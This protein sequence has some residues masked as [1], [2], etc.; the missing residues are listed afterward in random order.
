[1]SSEDILKYKNLGN[2]IKCAFA[3]SAGG[4]SI[5]IKG[6]FN[7]AF[8]FYVPALKKR[9]LK[10]YFW[11]ERYFCDGCE[12]NFERALTYIQN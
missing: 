11:S 6:L 4:F 3:F 12:S 7:P 5:R 9:Y 2:K 1:M 10:E 8:K